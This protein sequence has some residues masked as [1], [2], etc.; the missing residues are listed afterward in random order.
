MLDALKRLGALI[1]SPFTR[2]R[3]VKAMAKAGLPLTPAQ[4]AWLKVLEGFLVAGLVAAGLVLAQF[5][6]S[7]STDLLAMAR[8]ALAAFLVAAIMA[9]VKYAKAN[10][11][12]NVQNVA[13]ALDPVTAQ[14]IAGLQKWGNL[15]S[16]VPEETA[17]PE[18]AALHPEM[19]T[20]ED[21]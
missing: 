10:G 2:T 16:D 8:S 19:M 17:T 13:T 14:L 15:P 4:R 18:L 9:A 21:K 5:I 3:Q 1:A 11:D 7:G 6:A 12:A 20:P